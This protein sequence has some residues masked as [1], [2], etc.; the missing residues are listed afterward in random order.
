MG[1]RVDVKELP[2]DLA[3]MEIDDLAGQ[4]T[5]R[6]DVLERLFRRWPALSQTETR[7]LRVVYEE[8]VRIAR[9]LGRIRAATRS[10]PRE[11]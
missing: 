1:N 11:P 4:R 6:D 5:V 8:R 3:A 2:D 10:R 9:Y 7:L